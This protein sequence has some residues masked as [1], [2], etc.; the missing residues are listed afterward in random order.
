MDLSLGVIAPSICFGLLAYECITRS[1]KYTY[2]LVLIGFHLLIELATH[3]WP[4]ANNL[5]AL[6]FLVVLESLLFFLV[7]EKIGGLKSKYWYVATAIVFCLYFAI[8]VNLQSVGIV[9]LLDLLL[10]RGLLVIVYIIYYFLNNSKIIQGKYALEDILITLTAFIIF[11]VSTFYFLLFARL[12]T[13]NEQ[14]AEIYTTIYDPLFITFYAILV[15]GS[16]WRIL[17]S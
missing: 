15:I 12:S 6:C 16:L 14:L 17:R 9:N 11:Y 5:G 2:L 10:V 4:Q 1:S 3:I 13:T 8:Q 7:M